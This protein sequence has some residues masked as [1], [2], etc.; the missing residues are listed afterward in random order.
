MHPG[1]HKLTLTQCL[2]AKP[3][4][5]LHQ[6]SLTHRSSLRQHSL[7]L[8]SR[9]G[10]PS[11]HD[12]NPARIAARAV[13]PGGAMIGGEV[14]GTIFPPSQPDT[15]RVAEASAH[16]PRCIGSFVNQSCKPV[17]QTNLHRGACADIF[18]VRPRILSVCP[19]PRVQLT[20]TVPHSKRGCV[21]AGQLQ[22][23]QGLGAVILG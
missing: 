22:G 4:E 1:T 17:L 20:T 12:F 2:K 3:P 21:C 14:R 15:P 8:R 13:T 6:S 23:A 10:P 7:G 5:V 9:R 16:A 18:K 19:D 11:L